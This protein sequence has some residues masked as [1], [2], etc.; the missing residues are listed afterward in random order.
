MNRLFLL[1]LLATAVFNLTARAQDDFY[2]TRLDAAATQ[3]KRSTVELVDR[4]AE[5]LRR[6]LANTRADLDAAFLAHQLDASAGLFQQMV[7][8]K[9]R[10][11]ELRDGAA[12]LAEI[13]RRAP[14]SGPNGE[15]WRAA[16][17]SI[18]DIA[19]ELGGTTGGGNTENRPISGRV[20]WRGMVDDRVQ[21][22]IRDRQIETRVIGGRPYPDGTFSFTAALPTTRS[23]LV[24]VNK[25]KG[26]GAVRVVQQPSKAND[27]TTVVEIYDNEG[28]AREYQLDIYWK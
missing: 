28:G 20:Y 16:Q 18:S 7:R 21:L 2:S 23:A 10:A 4:T 27:F 26:R 12:I 13:A 17:T 1:A 14:G 19:R 24:E 3:L 8:D 22:V 6:N 25:T 9:R 5:D 11:G 15:L